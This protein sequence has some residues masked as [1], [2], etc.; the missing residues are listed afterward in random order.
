LT[1]PGAGDL[2]LGHY[3]KDVKTSIWRVNGNIAATQDFVDIP[4]LI[5]SCP[6]DAIMRE[7]PGI[8]MS[9]TATNEEKLAA[10]PTRFPEE[11]V[12]VKVPAF[13]RFVR[14]E[15]DNDYHLIL[16]TAADESAI[17]MTAEVSGLPAEGPD[18]DALRQVRDQLVNLIGHDPGKRKYEQPDQP[19]SVY[20]TGSLFFD[21]D[22]RPGRIGP[23]GCKPQTVWEIHPVIELQAR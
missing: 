15:T 16:G 5:A 19:L 14:K 23:R 8:D 10:A 20:V 2:F 13:L 12:N 6:D 18:L 22:H 3:R 4:A 21:G 7:R 11:Q 17:Y 1:T 9:P